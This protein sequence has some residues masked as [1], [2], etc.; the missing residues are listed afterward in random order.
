LCFINLA[1]L[2][3]NLLP[4][5]PL[6]GGQIVR[7]LAWF[8]VGRARSQ[9]ITVIIGFG[10]AA[11]LLAF[12]VWSGSFWIGIL[13][14][15]IL[16]NCWQGFRH[17]QALFRADQLPR[18]SAFRCPECHEAPFRGPFWKCGHCSAVFDTF[19]HCATC[20]GCGSRFDSTSCPQCGRA[21]PFGQWIPGARQ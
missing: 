8:V 7:A 16:M 9:L 12:A 20:P 3:F 6:D 14:A 21:H 15:F 1:I 10:G 4:I 18:H 11:A 13:S 2:V 5:Y 19:E 17:A